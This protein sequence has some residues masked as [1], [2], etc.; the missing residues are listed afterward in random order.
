MAIKG[1]DVS[2]FQKKIDWDKVKSRW[3][4]ICNIALWIWNGYKFTR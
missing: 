2:T 4:K 1:I 3:N